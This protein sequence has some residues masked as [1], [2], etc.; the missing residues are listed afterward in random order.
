MLRAPTNGLYEAEILLGNNQ[1]YAQRGKLTFASPFYNSNTGTFMVRASVDNPNG[2]LLPN[3]YVN[4]VL[5]G[6]I[7]PNAILLPQRAVQQGAGTN[8]VWV[9]G[10]NSHKRNIAQLQPDNGE[11]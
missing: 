7:R 11:A 9:V 2:A 4:V 8:Y 3:Q 6:A 5:K 10:K 1:I